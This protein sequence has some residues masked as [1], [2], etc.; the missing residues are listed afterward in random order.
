MARTSVE[1]N[2]IHDAREIVYMTVDERKVSGEMD[3]DLRTSQKVLRT[4]GSCLTAIR[5]YAK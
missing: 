3:G 4:L 1:R 2:L 5:L